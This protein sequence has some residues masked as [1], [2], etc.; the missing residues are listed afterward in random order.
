MKKSEDE[1][2]AHAIRS[3]Q[4]I[5]VAYEM[6]L[7]RFDAYEDPKLQAAYKKGKL[8]RADRKLRPSLRF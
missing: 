6:G 2:I 4:R 1:R 8:E 5:R 7:T 3:A